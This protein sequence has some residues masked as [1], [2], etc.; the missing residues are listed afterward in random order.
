MRD[1]TRKGIKRERNKDSGK[2]KE[3][4]RERDARGKIKRQTRKEGLKEK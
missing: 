3:Q 1:K 4:E 2:E